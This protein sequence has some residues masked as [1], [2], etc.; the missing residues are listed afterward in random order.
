M[1]SIYSILS[2]NV[3]CSIMSVVFISLSLIILPVGMLMIGN[4]AIYIWLA[5]VLSML[6]AAWISAGSF[7]TYF[8]LYDINNWQPTM[9]SHHRCDEEALMFP[10]FLGIALAITL[11]LWIMPIGIYYSYYLYNTDKKKDNIYEKKIDHA[12][13]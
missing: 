8:Y 4:I 11:P 9:Y 2:F 6:F 1:P 13:V 12:F 3:F 7:I 5:F 10:C